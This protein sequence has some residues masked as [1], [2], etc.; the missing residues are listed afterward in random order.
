MVDVIP[1][2]TLVFCNLPFSNLKYNEDAK[3]YVSQEDTVETECNID[4]S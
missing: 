2:L 1:M 4:W 3:S